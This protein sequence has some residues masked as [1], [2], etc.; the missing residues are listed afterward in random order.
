M[1]SITFST[2]ALA[3][4][5]P[6]AACG[7]SGQPN[8]QPGVADNAA[9]A[10]KDANEKTSPSMI[11]GEI[12]KAMQEAKQELATKNIDVNS[13]HINDNHHN[14]NDSRPKAEI[15]PQGE[16]LIAGKKVA[17]TPAQQTL[18]LDY[19][20]QI[21]GVAEAGT[22][23]GAKGADLGINAAKEALWGKLAGKSDKEIEA[24]IKPQTDKIEASA[25]R[26]CQRMPDLL[27]TQQKLAT[28][29][30]EF[31][32]YA[33]MQQKDVDD[34]GKDMTD[35]NGKKGTAVFSD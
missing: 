25:A 7:Q 32:P 34:C 2:L 16:L 11:S 13:V 30:P 1:K 18:L 12:Q 26:L 23:I 14:D 8:S 33:T 21:V 5:L 27:S 31:R 6:L 20:K 28:A 3:L 19:R 29:M 35:A 24:S 4:L 9:Q 10:L 22:D 15:T 17:A